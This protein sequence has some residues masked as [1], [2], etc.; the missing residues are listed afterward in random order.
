M[1]AEKTITQKIS[2]DFGTSILLYAAPVLLMLLSFYLSG[3]KPWQN[4]VPADAK[5]NGDNFIALIFNNLASWGLPAIM[6]VV[7]IIEF[8]HG[9]Y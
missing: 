6:V 1:K 9:L 7:G 5:V 3:A 4:Y 8:I 2:R